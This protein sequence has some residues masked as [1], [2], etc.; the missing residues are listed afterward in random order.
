MKISVKQPAVL[1]ATSA[2]QKALATPSATGA[3]HVPGPGSV[4]NQRPRARAMVKGIEDNIRARYG[5]LPSHGDVAGEV[6]R[7]GSESRSMAQLALDR[8]ASAVQGRVTRAMG[9]GKVTDAE[10]VELSQAQ[11]DLQEKKIADDL[12]LQGADQAEVKSGAVQQVRD[13]IESQ[14]GVDAF[15]QSGGT[16]AAARVNML[17]A[18]DDADP[19]WQRGVAAGWRLRRRQRR[20]RCIRRRR[21]DSD[22]RAGSID[23]DRR[24]LLGC[25]EIRCR[26]D[27][28][29]RSD[30]SV[31]S[32]RSSGDPERLRRAR[33]SGRNA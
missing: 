30:V 28:P 1:Q 27:A 33:L 21:A 9:D 6:K 23:V 18:T 17:R 20:R 12:V 14:G 8:T 26:S 31:A 24:R 11:L 2:V 19:D 13:G 32:R 25:I 4:E 10:R 16:G 7:R 3:T 29:R 15:L 5:A 22:S